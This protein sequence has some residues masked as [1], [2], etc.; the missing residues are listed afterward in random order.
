MFYV[1]T[2]KLW[3]GLDDSRIWLWEPHR[4]GREQDLTQK[5]L[6]MRLGYDR[7]TE[8][9]AKLGVLLDLELV[10]ERSFRKSVVVLRYAVRG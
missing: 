8:P 6:W 7:R 1:G 4:P 9:F 10:E 2:E 3:T 5:S